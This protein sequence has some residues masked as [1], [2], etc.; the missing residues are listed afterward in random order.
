VRQARER[1]LAEGGS[2]RPETETTGGGGEVTSKLGDLAVRSGQGLVDV[3]RLVRE[4]GFADGGGGV[5][6]AASG[7]VGS[8][9][10]DTAVAVGEGDAE[11]KDGEKAASA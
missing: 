4:K 10:K 7:L 6:E 3:V 9:R 8:L 2:E 5:G 1:G 11:G